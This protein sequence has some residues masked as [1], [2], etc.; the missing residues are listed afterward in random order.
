MR[1][2]GARLLAAVACAA[3][4]TR[5][6]APAAEARVL[7]ELWGGAFYELTEE[8]LDLVLAM[9]GEALRSW[10]V[11]VH[12][13]WCAKCAA[14]HPAWSEV[15]AAAASNDDAAAPRFA[16]IDASTSTAVIKRFGVKSF[17]EL[18]LFNASQATF[19]RYR[20]DF[21]AEALRALASDGAGALPEEPIRPASE[22]F[23][24]VQRASGAGLVS[25][26]AMSMGVTIAALLFLLGVCVGCVCSLRLVAVVLTCGLCGRE[27]QRK[28]GEKKD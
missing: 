22:E 24:L 1:P 11:Q 23:E 8:S 3:A 17:P 5:A 9:P 19:R 15:A 7:G 14:F 26:K 21:T 2:R 25:T 16:R 6:A 10:L 28:R 18:L 12:A 4:A 27:R 20:G 13:P